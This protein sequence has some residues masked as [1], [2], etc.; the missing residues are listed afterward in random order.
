MENGRIGTRVV[1]P[2]L[3]KLIL[4]EGESPD[5]LGVAAGG[6]GDGFAVG[7]DAGAGLAVVGEGVF[8]FAFGGSVD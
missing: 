2:L 7:A 6:E 5:F 1:V 4:A 8:L 3:G